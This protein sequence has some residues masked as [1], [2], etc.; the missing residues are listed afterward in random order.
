MCWPQGPGC[1][2]GG[3]YNFDDVTTDGSL[4][5]RFLGLSWQGLRV[6]NS[7]RFS[8]CDGNSGFR[9][10]VVSGPNVAY[11]MEVGAS[12][13]MTNLVRITAPTPS[14]RISVLGFTATAAWQVRGC[15]WLGRRSS[16]CGL[17][18][19]CV[20]TEPH[21]HPRQTA[22]DDF[23]ALFWA[24]AAACCLQDGLRIDVTAWDGQDRQIGMSVFNLSFFRPTV[25]DLRS[26]L[27]FSGI[28]RLQII[29]SGGQKVSCA[30]GKQV[31][32]DNLEVYLHG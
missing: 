12:G 22:P 25:I 20:E 24:C 2:A 21:A 9:Y 18:T 29:T 11:S 1:L 19:S 26:D 32:L 3:V 17:L 28:Y 15:S 30:T 27:R 10:G 13:D 4:P 6:T 7:Q 14:S 16:V 31:V 5:N 8:A 23:P